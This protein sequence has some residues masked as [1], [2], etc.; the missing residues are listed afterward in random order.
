MTPE[1]YDAWYDTPR[2]SWIG[3]REWT[4]VRNALRLQPGDS[5]L[6]IGCG[7]GWFT[8]RAGA[9]A[10]RVVG[11][12]TDQRSLDFARRMST[13]RTEYLLGD[14]TVLPFEDAAFDRVMSVAALCFVS[15]WKRALSEIVRV[16]RHRFAIGLLNCTSV[17]YLR[18]GRH[19]GSGAYAGA[20]WHTARELR[21]ALQDLRPADLKISYGVFVTSGSAGARALE[22]VVPGWLPL[23][24]FLLVSGQPSS[25]DSCGGER[26]ARA[27]PDASGRGDDL[28]ALPRGLKSL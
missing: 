27:R 18:K 15:D 6:D 26:Q 2:G 4:M 14:A 12:D 3:E 28:G 17:L 1:D 24:S 25:S 7:T 13:D 23:G 10:T 8:R 21:E 16:S 20:H 9:V 11:L 5:V 22:R 19:G